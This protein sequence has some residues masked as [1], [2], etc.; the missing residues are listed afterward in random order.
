MLLQGLLVGGARPCVVVHIEISLAGEAAA[1][2]GTVVERLAYLWLQHADDR[3]DERAGGVVLATVAPR[4]AHLPQALL[5][6]CR[7]LVLVVGRLEVEFI[8][9]LNDAAQRV[10]A[11][12]LVG[13]LGEDDADLV[14][15]GVVAVF[16]LELREVGP[17]LRVD[18]VEEVLAHEG[19][20]MVVVA[21]GVAW[22]GPCAPAVFAV[23]EA[24]VRLT[25]ELGLELARLLHVI[26]I[27][28]EQYPRALLH[29]VESRGASRVLP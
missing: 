13:D 15:D 17:Q 25:G 5:I 21:L 24:V 3:A 19:V 9:L 1:A 12:Q 29:I 10:A 2:R 28:Q 4:V 7:H 14:F 20:G 16:V 8:D 23:D 18:E 11:R 22:H 27:L 26:E 6:E